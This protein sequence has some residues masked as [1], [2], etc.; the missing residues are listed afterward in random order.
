MYIVAEA[1]SKA[2]VKSATLR[3]L[4]LNG[5]ISLLRDI[6]HERVKATLTQTWYCPDPVQRQARFEVESRKTM[7]E[8]LEDS[9]RHLRHQIYFS[10]PDQLLP[11]KDR[12]N[13]KVSIRYI[14]NAAVESNI[15]LQDRFI[16][17]PPDAIFLDQQIEEDDDFLE[18]E[19]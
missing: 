14:L 2:A 1:G 17:H 5:V 4:S 15:D 11:P 3:I 16:D 13:H 7:R 19:D 18:E 10:I 6:R 8:W 9:A 12:P